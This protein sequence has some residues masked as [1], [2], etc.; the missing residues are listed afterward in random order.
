VTFTYTITDPDG[1]T[2]TA[3][4]T[5]EYEFKEIE[6]SQG[7]SPNGDGNNDT[8]FIKGIES[9]PD[10]IVKVYNRW[11]LLVYIKD[12]YENVFQPWNG[13][14]NTGLD[15]GKLVDKGTYFY[16]VDPGGGLKALSGFVV[17]VR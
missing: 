17:V 9:Y 4:V 5:I 7:F 8:W 3:V 15:S 10:N 2:D 11:G 1:L 16:I 12:H 14:A 6:V 13:R